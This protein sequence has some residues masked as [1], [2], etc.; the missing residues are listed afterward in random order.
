MISWPTASAAA[1][2][3]FLGVGA[4]VG[5][6]GLVACGGSGDRAIPTATVTQGPFDVI[7]AVPGELEAVNSVSITAPDLGRTIKITSIAEEG[8]RVSEGDV[9]V[10]FDQNELLDDLEQAEAKLEVAQTKIAQQKTQLDVRMADLENNVVKAELALERA[11]MR[12]SESETVP[13]VDR[14]SA[15]IDVRESQL[16]LDSSRATLEQERLQAQAELQLL[17]LEVRQEELKVQRA[18]ERLAKAT[19]TAPADGLVILADIWKGGSMGRVQAGDTVWRGSAL[20]S[21]PDLSEM[22]VKSWVHEVDAGKVAVGQPVS[23]VIDAH[24]DPAWQA[25]VSKVAD[26][27]VKRDGSDVVKHVKIEAS[28]AE[29]AETMKP[30]MTV[31]AEILVDHLDEALSIPQEAVFVQGERTYVYREA[32][33]GFD[34]IDVTLGIRNDT[35]VVVESGLEAGDV[36]ALVDPERFEAGEPLPAAQAPAEPDES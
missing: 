29:T 2:S 12:V 21:L 36:V 10:E 35:H 18:R 1:M 31:R 19:A 11:Q 27:A 33:R 6:L 22:Q 7:L 9:V 17:E 32:F 13:L 3:R 26:L 28:L 8:S 20:M 25:E 15:K 24:P 4:V 16:S 23:I 5:A 30:G 14:E 34:D